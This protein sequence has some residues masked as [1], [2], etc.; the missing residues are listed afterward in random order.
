[1]IN[2]FFKSIFVGRVITLLLLLN[3]QYLSA[4][5]D[6]FEIEAIKV[7]NTLAADVN[8]A[9]AT[10]FNSINTTAVINTDPNIFTSVTTNGVNCVAGTYLVNVLLHHING[11]A[12]NN[13]YVEVT[14]N[15]VSTNI[16]G[17]DGFVRRANGHD[18]GTTSVADLVRLTTPRKI[19]FRTLRLAAAGVAPAPAGRSMMR[20]VRIDD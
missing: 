14:V 10:Q 20:I 12:L 1:M 19:G 2:N 13:P 3:F 4:A 18:E 17:A 11:T 5:Y 15:S 9:A 7:T 16:R 8:Q 6:P